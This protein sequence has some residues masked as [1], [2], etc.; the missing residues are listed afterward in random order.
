[1]PP[2]KR[3]TI[4]PFHCKEIFSNG[5]SLNIIKSCE[6]YV[7]LYMINEKENVKEKAEARKKRKEWN[8]FAYLSNTLIVFLESIGY[9]ITY[10]KVKHS[11]KRLPLLRFESIAR[12]GKV[13]INEINCNEIGNSIYEY[14][15]SHVDNDYCGFRIHPFN[16][17]LFISVIQND[18]LLCNYSPDQIIFSNS[19]T[20]Y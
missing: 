15:E 4:R 13:F 2:G 14:L 17:V 16:R 20:L 5:N 19:I 9:E 18:Y 3:K 11:S 6:Q 12:N 7:E 8:K 1:M 10:K